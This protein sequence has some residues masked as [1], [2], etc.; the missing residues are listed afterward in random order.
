MKIAV[1]KLKQIL[2][3]LAV[4]FKV[5]PIYL[6]YEFSFALNTLLSNQSS[7]GLKKIN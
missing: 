1:Y 5:K 2:F 4:I 3:V 6:K 7:S